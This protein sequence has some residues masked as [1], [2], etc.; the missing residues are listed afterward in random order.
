MA[1]VV[2]PR[3]AH[4][5]RI[6]AVA[7]AVESP[8]EDHGVFYGI[9]ISAMPYPIWNLFICHGTSAE[10]VTRAWPAIT[11]PASHVTVEAMTTL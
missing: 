7:Y 3:V 1:H 11:C 8:M 2:E 10:G 4:H 6:C 9:R 5:G